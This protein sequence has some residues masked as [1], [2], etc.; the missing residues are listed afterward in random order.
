M[1]TASSAG[2]AAAGGAMVRLGAVEDLVE[3]LREACDAARSW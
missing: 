1:L 2:G 3:A